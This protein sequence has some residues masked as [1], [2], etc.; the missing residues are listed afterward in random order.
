[1]LRIEFWTSENLVKK[2]SKRPRDP[3]NRIRLE[4]LCPKVVSDRKMAGRMTSKR[5]FWHFRPI[6]EN[7]ALN[8][9]DSLLSSFWGRLAGR[10]GEVSQ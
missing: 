8:V 7:P 9:N 4:K 2:W 5:R 10:V 3:Q 1:M 6:I